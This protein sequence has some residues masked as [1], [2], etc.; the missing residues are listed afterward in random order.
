MGDSIL[1]V[2]PGASSQ[3]VAFILGLS[4]H[5]LATNITYVIYHFATLIRIKSCGSTDPLAGEGER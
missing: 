4:Q 2:F 1:R 5:G 3:A